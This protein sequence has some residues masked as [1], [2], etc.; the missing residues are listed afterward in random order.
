MRW[1]QFSARDPR[2]L[3]RARRRAGRDPRRAARRLAAHPAGAGHRDVVRRGADR[4]RCSL[5]PSRYEGP[6]GIVGVLQDAC[7]RA[8]IP[9]L[10]I[11]AAVPHYVAQPPCPKATL[12]LLR[13]HRGPA[14]RA[15]PARRPARGRAGLGARRRR[16]GRARTPRSPTT[17]ARSRRPRTPPTLPEAVR[18]RDRPGVRALPAPPRG[19]TAAQLSTCPIP[20]CSGHDRYPGGRP[21]AGAARADRAGRHRPRRRPGERGRARRP[22]RR[23]P[24]DR[25]P[26][27]GGAARRRG[28]SRAAAAPGWFVTGAS[29]HQTPRARAPS[30]TPSPRS[31]QAGKSAARRVVDFG[32]RAGPRRDRRPASGSTAAREALHAPVGPQRRRRAARPRPRV[33]AR[34]RW[35]ARSAGPTPTAPASGPPCSAHGHRID[36]GPADRSPPALASAEDAEL[37]GRAAGTPAAARPPARRRTRPACRSPC[38]TTATWPTGSASRSSSAAGP[39]GSAAATARPAGIAR[40]P[41]HPTHRPPTRTRR[42]HR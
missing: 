35:P 7:T 2:R 14:R 19:R 1:R 11:W 13:Q 37:L 28:W 22:V 27:A 34:R 40:R 16:A 38:P 20:V 31:P 30:G 29:F 15:D 12:A 24:G 21:G 8:G 25:A 26:G 3:P 39:S 42:P 18:R 33:G 23:E 5:E 36:V 10:S 41:P 4:G 32:Y 9:A 17:S 6:T